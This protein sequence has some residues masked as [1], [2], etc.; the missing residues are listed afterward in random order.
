MAPT[1]AARVFCR[2]CGQAPCLL[3]GTVIPKAQPQRFHMHAKD[4]ADMTVCGI[5]MPTQVKGSRIP[6]CASC[7]RLCEPLVAEVR[8]N[9][10]EIYGNPKL[11]LRKRA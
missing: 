10:R 6:M 2:E 4:D 5:P 3:L 8:P 7:L 9:A 1:E 11:Q